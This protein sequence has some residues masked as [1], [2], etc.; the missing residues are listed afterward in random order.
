MK[1]V[2]LFFALLF[3]LLA[4]HGADSQSS[5]EPRC[6]NC[7]CI[8]GES[9]ESESTCPTDTSGIW[10]SFP[11]AWIAS[12]KSFQLTSPARTLQAEDG[13]S[14]SSCYPFAG[15]VDL[16]LV[17]YAESQVSPCVMPDATTVSSSSAA[18]CAFVSIDPS[19]SGRQYTVQDFE[20]ADAAAASSNG[21]AQVI[22]SGP[23]GVCSNA[24]DLAVRMENI[25]TLKSAS[26]GCG[27]DYAVGGNNFANLVTCYEKVGFTNPCA[28]LWAH[29][30]AT[31]SKLCAAVCIPTSDGIAM[32]DVT[33]PDCPYT[34]CYNC[35][36]SF[37]EDFNMLAGIWYVVG[38]YQIHRMPL[39]KKR[40][41]IPSLFPL[42]PCLV[43]FHFA[44]EVRVQCRF[45]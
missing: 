6:D 29:Y 41:S 26:I 11:A 3:A 40:S 37:G 18:V 10:Q 21:T 9:E 5:L 44:K 39:N 14:G 2:F 27:F 22:H 31:N 30:T 38:L 20:S 4:T 24:I 34:A 8:P 12:Y 32:N 45:Q 28:T 23:C 19:C 35:S 15:S 1:A 7:W 36:T 33:Q 43:L 17:T 25:D 42:M 13:S 16:A